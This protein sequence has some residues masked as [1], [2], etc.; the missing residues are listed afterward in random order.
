M[1]IVEQSIVETPDGPT[2]ADQLNAYRA[3]NDAD[4]VAVILYERCD[5]QI[6]Y[7]AIWNN[8]SLAE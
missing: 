7:G 3:E 2:L 5:H 1:K 8:W 6:E 4:L